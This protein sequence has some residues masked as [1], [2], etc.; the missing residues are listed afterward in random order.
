MK[1]PS[2]FSWIIEGR[3]AGSGRPM[4]PRDLQWMKRQG[5]AALLSLTE[6]PLPDGW[7]EK[8]ELIYSNT[9]LLDHKPPTVE[10]IEETVNFITDH[11]AK[12]N[13]V[14]VHCAAGQGRTGTILASYLIKTDGLTAE[15]AI[16]KIRA[17]RP[18]SIEKS[19]EEALYNY[20]K[21]LKNRG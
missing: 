17:I 2:N 21:H 8:A 6:T 14:A 1:K 5:V 12:G 11:L 10:Q 18:P 13:P 16:K 19:Q 9:P 7:A 15:E 3:L 4:N 20:E